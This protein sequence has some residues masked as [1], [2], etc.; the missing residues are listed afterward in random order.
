MLRTTL[1]GLRAHRLRL[2]LTAVAIT[3][4]V[5]F[6]AGTFVLTDTIQ[7]GISRSFGAAADSIDVVVLP[8]P[9]GKPVVLPDRTLAKVRQVD[10]VASA[11]GLIRGTAALVGRDGKTVGDHPTR[12]MSID[13]RVSVTK[14]AA[15]RGPGEAVLDENTARLRGFAVGQAI[16]VLD[17]KDA[18]HRFRLT[19]LFDVG[20]DQEL[21]YF[22][23][24][25]FD[26]ATARAMTGVKGYAEIDVKAAPGVA[27]DRLRA[28]VA[29]ATGAGPEVLTGK[30]LA[31]RLIAANGASAEFI[32]L[33]LLLFGVVAMLVAA[34]V[35][36]N[37]F[38]ILVAQRTR[39]MALL[40]CVGA[41]RRQV[42]GSVL[43]ESALVGVVCSALGLLAGLGMGGAAL[44]VLEGMDVPLPTGTVALAPRTITVGLAVGVLVTVGAAVLPART[45]TRVPPVAALRTQPE[46]AVD[47]PGAGTVRRVAAGL[48]LAAGAAITTVAVTVLGPG[49]AALFT[50]MGGGM[51]TFLG[52]LVIGPVL[53]RPLSAVAGWPPARLFGVPGR[54]AVDNSRRNPRRSATTTIAL[55]IGV[56]L[57]TMMAVL[58]GSIRANYNHKL[59]EQFPVDFMLST[60]REGSHIP[61]GV[62]DGLRGRPELASLVRVRQA[63]TAVTLGGREARR[64]VGA[65]EGPLEVSASS[66]SARGLAPG[67]VLAAE[68]LGIRPGGTLTLTPDKGG[69]PGEPVTLRVAATFDANATPLPPLVM[70]PAEF[71][72]YFDVSGDAQ[73]MVDVAPG[74]DP[75]RARKV[76][77]EAARPYPAV[78]VAASTDIRGQFDEALDTQLMVVTGLLGLAILISLLGIANT[79]SLS[80]HERT[81]E[82]ALLRALGLTRPQLRLMLSVEALVLGLIGALVGVALGM[83]FGWAAIQTMFA[84]PIYAPPVG[85]VLTFVAL[86]GLAGVLAAV[87]PARRAARARITAA[88]SET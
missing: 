71:A 42:F 46:A 26:A 64:T 34:L 44:A 80:V 66:G 24:V 65:Y 27:A 81:R 60:Q 17:Q 76:L 51:V 32:A 68:G 33:G 70:P 72:R 21:A 13:S 73:I 59:E 19:G 25:G 15:P 82:S 50:V 48:L 86:S 12:G 79:L 3:L 43:L 11:D 77:E 67:S 35:I 37:T 54:L 7:A 29:S 84:D 30:A 28:A 2:M 6:I 23:A 49:E 9:G 47:G 40:R 10:G 61:S 4:G 74:A 85:Q 31:D 1:A 39:E 69:E 5:G 16:T 36:Y 75:D 52:V 38:A 83:V 53:V 55:T 57:M 22:G 87:L 18:P 45:A 20:V 88:L 78:R 62:G 58:T 41:T 63:E 8:P 14:G 56:T